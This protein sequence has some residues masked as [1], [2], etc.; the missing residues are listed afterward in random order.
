VSRREPYHGIWSAFIVAL[1][2]LFAA[3]PAAMATSDPSLEWFTLESE[4]FVLHYHTGLEKMAVDAL[5]VAE[6]AY[7]RLSPLLR[8]TPGAR[9]HIV[10]TDF[11]DSANGMAGVVPYNL[12][13]L[14]AAA[15]T[16]RST[17]NDY[18]DWLRSLIFHE[19]VHILHLDTMSGVPALINVIFGKTVAPNG[20]LPRWFTEGLATYYE[21]ARTGAG[22]IRNGVFKMCLRAAALDDRLFSLGTLSGAPTQWPGVRAWYLYGGHFLAYVAATRGESALTDFNHA[23]GERL[24]PFGVNIVARQTL[25]DDWPTLYGEWQTA[26]TADALAQWVAMRAQGGPTPYRPLNKRSYAHDFIQRRPGHNQLSFIRNDGLDERMLVLYDLESGEETEVFEEHGEGWHAWSPDGQF[27]VTAETNFYERVY[28]YGDLY[29]LDL[30]TGDHQL[31]TNGERA[32]EPVV[33]PDGRSV[34][35]IAGQRGTTDLKRLWL[36][37]GELEVL[38][39]GQAYEQISTPNF[40]PEGTRLVVSRFSGEPVGRRDLFLFDLQTKVWTRLTDD[41]ALD[42]EPRFDPTGEAIIFSADR[43]GTFEL[44]RADLVTGALLQLTRSVTGFF[45]PSFDPSGEVLYATTYDSDGYNVTTLS[46]PEL[47]ASA[48]PAIVDRRREVVVTPAA[49][50]VSHEA[51]SYQPWRF[52][53]PS[54]WLPEFLSTL[55]FDGTYALSLMGSDPAGYHIW[56]ARLAYNTNLEDLSFG[57]TYAYLGLP[58]DLQLHLSRGDSARRF[59]GSDGDVNYQENQTFAGVDAVLPL[60][61]PDFSHTLSASFNLTHYA[62]SEP[63]PSVVARDPI[64]PLPR[65]PELG[66]FNNVRLGW[67]FGSLDSFPASVSTESGFSLGLSVGMR[68]PLVG[69]DFSSFDVSYQSALYLQ[70]PWLDNHVFAIRLAGGVGWA[71]YNRRGLFIVGGIPEQD[72]VMALIN[73]FG[74]GS[75]QLRG[76]DVV[77]S[78]GDE[79]HLLNSEYRFPIFD[80]EDGY[81]T[82]PAY[83]GRLHGALFADYGGAFFGGIDS[84]ALDQFK[85]GVG[86]ELRMSLVLGYHLPSMLRLG[87]AYGASEGGLHHLYLVVGSQF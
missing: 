58:V 32:R 70:N 51:H 20:S 29:K 22:R 81:D 26:L 56:L 4:H 53:W 55:S 80:I 25:G 52:L 17:L 44:Y 9:T 11:G 42:L 60:P 24:I 8:W 33:A 49:P 15:P 48:S 83:L 78:Y 35:Y 5:A 7:E 79:Y 30:E 82:L 38:Y 63:L 16:S 39:E 6:E 28:V 27:L 66:Y 45:S 64:G 87:Y 21:S 12:M 61:S 86:A 36:D 68:S 18:D 69:S 62:P 59:R 84:E 43:T 19:Y 13:Q 3:P 72:L 73:Q 54:N 37:T 65:F 40:D 57:A 74:V 2:L 71:D 47:M 23:Y 46:V 34:V 31:L 85:L 50:R 75:A 10:L 76:Y 14:Y 67:S 77:D 1:C 41:K